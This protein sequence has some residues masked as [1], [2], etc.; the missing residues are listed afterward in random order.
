MKKKKAQLGTR[1]KTK[2]RKL[3]EKIRNQINLSFHW[4][5]FSLRSQSYNL[6]LDLS[7]LILKKN[8][9]ILKINLKKR[10][11]QNKR[12]IYLMNQTVLIYQI[13]MMK[14]VILMIVQMDMR[15]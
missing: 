1:M 13:L 14:M 11:N 8:Q 4:L 15:K 5:D 2:L 3:E 12:K 9:K 10:R 6:K 7:L